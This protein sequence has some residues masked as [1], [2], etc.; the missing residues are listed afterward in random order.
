MLNVR[1]T[2]FRN[3]RSGDQRSGQA[4]RRHRKIVKDVGAR[5]D[6]PVRLDDGFGSM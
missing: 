2:S 1:S 4:G 5:N 6:R 3:R